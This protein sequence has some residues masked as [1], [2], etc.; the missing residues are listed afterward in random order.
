M[1]RRKLINSSVGRKFYVLDIE[2]MRGNFDG[3]ITAGEV[4]RIRNEVERILPVEN[5]DQVVIGGKVPDK[6]SM[7]DMTAQT[8]YCLTC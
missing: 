6:C 8:S 1:S 3:H 7:A 5:M 2:N 4:A